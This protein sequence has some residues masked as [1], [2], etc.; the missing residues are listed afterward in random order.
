MKKFKKWF[1]TLIQIGLLGV[2]IYSG[3]QIG[4]YYYENYRNSQKLKE[5]NNIV[6]E[7]ENKSKVKLNESEEERK[8]RLDAL[9][10]TVIENLK[11][12]N[13]DIVAF[14][15]FPEAKISFPV[16]WAENDNFKYLWSD[17]D[18]NN[19][20]PGTIFL[21]GFNN[22][23]FNDM[24]STLFGHNLRTNA[25][26]FAPM[27][28]LLLDFDDPSKVDTSRDYFIEIYTEEGYRRYQVFSGYYSDAYDNYIFTNI[29]V[30]EWTDYLN[31]RKDRSAVNYNVNHEFKMGDKLLTLS[32]CDYADTEVGEDG[33]FVMHAVL[34]D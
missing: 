7:I 6:E 33:R 11:K 3:H 14:I 18:L 16:A 15:K 12:K 4:T 5:T 28:K 19:S 1:L 8:H 29:D 31:T 20:R 2:M 25:E 26:F 13:Q 10:K 17:L 34:V 24:N 22:P 30:Q 21:N 23:D 32:T 9:A 27:F